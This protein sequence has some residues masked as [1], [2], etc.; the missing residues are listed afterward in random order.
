MILPD[1]NVLI[2]AFR[3]DLPDHAAYRRWLLEVMADDAAFSAAELVLSGVVRVL[4]HPRVFAQPDPLAEALAF[5][6]AIRVR[7]NCVIVTPGP[8]HWAIF[9]R[10]CEQVGAKGGMVTDAHLAALAIEHGLTL[11]STDGDFAR[12]AGLSWKNPLAVSG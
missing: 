12:F 7:P 3:P 8:R 10:L 9:T 1:V 11:C 2:Y 6:N 5:V 4:T